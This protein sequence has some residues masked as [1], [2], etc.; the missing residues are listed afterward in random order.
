[1]RVRTMTAFTTLPFSTV[2]SGEASFTAAVT[3]SPSPAVLP[4]PPPSGRITCSLRAPELSATASIVL[5]CT[6]SRSPARGSHPKTCSKPSRADHLTRTCRSELRLD[7]LLLVQ[8]CQRRP[9]HNLLQRPPLQLGQRT[10]LADA[11]HIAHARRVRLVMRIELAVGLHHTLILRVRL[12]HLDLDHDRLLHLGRYHHADFLI[13]ARCGSFIR[14]GCVIRCLCHRLVL[15][16]R[17]LGRGFLRGSLLR[18]GLRGRFLRRLCFGCRN[19][20]RLLRL[21][22]AFNVQLALALDCLDACNVQ[23]Q[24]AQLLHALRIA[25]L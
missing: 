13:A 4:S 18:C 5:I 3:T 19:G 21:C 1:L 12:A 23:L 8:L 11:H 20:C 10:R 7:R 6:I 22:L 16:G 9:P 2:T 25:Q 14:S 17:F 24:A 15:L